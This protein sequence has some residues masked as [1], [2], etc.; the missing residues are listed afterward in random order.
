MAI[1]NLWPTPAEPATNVKVFRAEVE[2]PFRAKG[3]LTFHFVERVDAGAKTFSEFRPDLT[4]SISWQEALLDAELQAD[5]QAV[6]NRLEQIAYAM[7]L[8]MKAR[9]EGA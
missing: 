4:M 1:P 2:D 3:Q 9:I 6:K 8:R 7:Y 5:A